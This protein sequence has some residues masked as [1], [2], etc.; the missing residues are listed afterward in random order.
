MIATFFLFTEFHKCWITAIKEALAVHR[1]PD[2]KRL[3]HDFSTDD[4]NR[5]DNN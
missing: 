1:Y 2:I 4:K 3:I 5:L